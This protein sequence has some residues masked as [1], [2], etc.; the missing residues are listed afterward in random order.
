MGLTTKTP[1]K[2]IMRCTILV[3]SLAIIYATASPMAEDHIIPEES[4]FAL[5]DDLSEAQQ[6][7]NEMTSAGKSDKDCRKLVTET[8]KD[9]ET[10]VNSCQKTMDALPNGKEC[11]SRG[12]AGVKTATEAKDK[13]DKHYK[14]TVTEV[15]KASSASVKFGSRTFSSLTEGK[16]ES[17][18]TSSSYTTAE[19][20]YKAAV[21]ARTT[22]KGAAEQADKELKAAIEAAAKAKKECECQ[23]KKDHEEKFTKLSAADAA[24]KKA[25]EFACK[26][27]C[28]LDGKTSCRCSAAPQCKRAKLTAAVNAAQCVVMSSGSVVMRSK[29]SRHQ[30]FSDHLWIAKSDAEA[31]SLK[32][33][34]K[35]MFTCNGAKYGPFTITALNLND[36]KN[37]RD[38][39][40]RLG[41][42]GVNLAFM[43]LNGNLHHKCA[44]NRDTDKLQ[45]EGMVAAKKCNG[46]EPLNFVSASQTGTMSGHNAVTYG[47]KQAI[48]NS[49]NTRNGMKG[50]GAWTGD[51]GKLVELR[52]LKVDWEACQCNNKNSVAIQTSTDG[53]TWK[54]CG[55]WGAS[56]SG[57]SMVPAHM[58]LRNMA[59]QARLG[60]FATPPQAT[61]A[62]VNGCRCGRLPLRV[63]SK[64]PL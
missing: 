4:L 63:A 29:Y 44:A 12:Q 37:I 49:G 18:Y 47:P 23:V 58:M 2:E 28:V 34:D 36:G 43:Q 25:W 1:L 20:T 56:I 19:A 48:D 14:Y 6:K 54:N 39:E 42:T 55:Y 13:A 5:D 22:A 7:V 52:Q 11:P 30:R 60:M 46:K 62:R 24:N 41:G 16:C 17:F 59:V 50:P 31:M 33:G 26:V 61:W 27:E 51:F 8:R 15:T 35:L 38:G 40:P 64:M 21:T 32:K 57:V 45:K 3:L 53:K 10:N 9:I